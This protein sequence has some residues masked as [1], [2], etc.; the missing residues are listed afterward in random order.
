MYTYSIPV[1]GSQSSILSFRIGLE[2]ENGV[3]FVTAPRD[4]RV[5]NCSNFQS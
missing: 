2:S 1:A 5:V 3:E 4:T